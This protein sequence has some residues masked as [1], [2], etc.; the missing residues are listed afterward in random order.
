[1]ILET[2]D[3]QVR[4]VK[5]Y[6]ENRITNLKKDGKDSDSLS[7]YHEMVIIGEKESDDW[8]FIPHLESF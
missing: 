6:F 7:L 2:Q 5:N 8:L 3:Q 4:Y 1:M